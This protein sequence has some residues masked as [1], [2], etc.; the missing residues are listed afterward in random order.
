M[1]ILPRNELFAF[2]R[3][4]EQVVAPMDKPASGCELLLLKSQ[5]ITLKLGSVVQR[6]RRYSRG[7]V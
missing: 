2:S 5:P 4:S 6:L 7:I 3:E 1:P